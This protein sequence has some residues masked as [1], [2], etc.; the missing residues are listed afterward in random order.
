MRGQITFEFIGTVVVAMLIYAIFT[1]YIFVQFGALLPWQNQNYEARFYAERVAGAIDAAYFGGDGY[2]STFE[3]P[4]KIRGRE[5]NVEY[6]GGVVEVDIVDL[7]EVDSYGIAYSMAP[8]IGAFDAGNGT[9]HVTN[10]NGTV[11]VWGQ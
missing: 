9:N 8:E 1:A 11:G 10:S 5:Y 3:L 2:Y 7:G 4:E 6:G